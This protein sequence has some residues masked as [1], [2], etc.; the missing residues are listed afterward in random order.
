M[1]TACLAIAGQGNIGLGSRQESHTKGVSS[2]FSKSQHLQATGLN[3][4]FCFS[5]VAGD[6]GC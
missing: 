1:D 6:C 3:N 4:S 2:S 5:N